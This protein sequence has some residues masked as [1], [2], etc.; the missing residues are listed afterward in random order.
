MMI[1]HSDHPLNAEPPLERLRASFI[2]PAADFYI[3]CHGEIPRLD[4][5]ACRLTVNGLVTRPLDLS[6]EALRTRFGHHTICAVLQCAGNRRAELHAV[7]PV[8]GD[9]WQAGAI[10]NARWTGVGLADVLREAGLREDAAHIAFETHD[11]MELEGERFRFGVSIPRDKAMSPEVLLAFAMNGEPLAPEHGFPLRLV[12]PGFAGVRSP[13]WLA[14]ITAQD[15]PADTPVQQRD[16]K[17]LPL[18]M[19]KETADW[20]ALGPI[21]EMPLNSAICTPP[22]GASLPAGLVTVTGY[23]V[24]TARSIV[25]VDVSADGGRSWRQA[26]LHAHP[27]AHWSWMLWSIEIDLP[28]GGHELAVRAWDSAGQTQ[29][30][31]PDDVWN[32]MGYLC[33]T[34][35][36]VPVRVV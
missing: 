35:N 11:S 33:A 17:L 36:R 25:R 3:R 9:P 23:A 20:P 16:Y 28:P 1:V 10:G 31:S 26:A 21:N 5:A 18:R 8:S 30:A 27:E 24:A 19:T 2:T 4:A 7:R 15:Q 13:K 12:T 32:A 34:W 22:R 6:R 14:T 29:P